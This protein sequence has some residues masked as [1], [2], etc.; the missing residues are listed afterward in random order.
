MK[1]IGLEDIAK[2]VSFEEIPNRKSHIREVKPI[3][4]KKVEPPKTV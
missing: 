2:R 1:A 3:S 4:P